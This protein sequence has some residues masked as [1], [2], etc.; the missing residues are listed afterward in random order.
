MLKVL[1]HV[2]Q[3]YKSQPS[4][5]LPT[6]SLL[7]LL[8]TV[9]K[10]NVLTCNFAVGYVLSSLARD[11]VEV[12][13][14]TLLSL[15]SIF[16]QFNEAC[17]QHVLSAFVYNIGDIRIKAPLEVRTADFAFASNEASKRAFLAYATELLLW[18][19]RAPTAPAAGG[20]N[21][22]M[23]PQAVGDANT[24]IAPGHSTDS[25]TAIK[26]TPLSAIQA[27]LP[28]APTIIP[29]VGSYSLQTLTERKV[30]LVNFL[31][32]NVDIFTDTDLYIP[33]IIASTDI[34]NDVQHVGEDL[35]RK[36]SSKDALEDVAI[37]KR[38]FTLFVG[39]TASASQA[40]APANANK[41]RAPASLATGAKILELLSRSRTAPTILPQAIMVL[42][43]GLLATHNLTH[44]KIQTL[45]LVFAQQVVRLLSPAQLNATSPAILSV[46]SKFH[47][48]VKGMSK[49]GNASQVPSP[50]QLESL[51]ISC[52]HAISALGRR[53]P[54]VFSNN[55]DLIEELLNDLQDTTSVVLASALQEALTSICPTSAV[56][57]EAAQLRLKN[58]LA[59]NFEVK[60]DGTPAEGEAAQAAID[61]ARKTSVSVRY[62]AQYYA[63]RSFPFSDVFLRYINLLGT[64]DANNQVA[65]E[66]KIGLRPFTVVD[67]TI[68]PLKEAKET[69][70]SP[71]AMDTDSGN[72]SATP[73]TW[74]SFASMMHLI[75][76][77]LADGLIMASSTF[78]SMIVFLHDLMK[79]HRNMRS[80]SLQSAP[81]EDSKNPNTDEFAQ[82]FYLK[83]LLDAIVQNASNNTSYMSAEH[84]LETM[85]LE[86][87]PGDVAAINSIDHVS[88]LDAVTQTL[89]SGS[90]KPET[91]RI[92]SRIAGLLALQTPSKIASLVETSFNA[93]QNNKS[94]TVRD[95]QIGAVYTLSS[96]VAA[97][98]RTKVPEQS[99]GKS[100]EEIVAMILSVLQASIASKSST[101]LSG[102]GLMLATLEAIGFIG[103]W[104][105]K[106]ANVKTTGNE[107]TLLQSV[108][109]LLPSHDFSIVINAA[110][111]VGNLCL[112]DRKLI[113]D[114]SV[115]KGL[116]ATFVVKNE[117]AH[118]SIGEALSMVAYGWHAAVTA[119]TMIH[120]HQE[121]K[122]QRSKQSDASAEELETGAMRHILQVTLKDYFLSSRPDTR[123]A[124]AIWLLTILKNCGAHPEVVAQLRSIQVGFQ[125]LLG[126][127]N[128][129][130]QEVAGKALSLVYELGDESTK[131][132]LVDSLV[133]ALQK[134]S[135]STFKV[136]A[137]SEIFATG[138]VGM[139]PTGD[140][141]T[142]YRELVTLA[143]EMNQPDL[144]Y[145]FM[146]LSSHNALWNSKKGAAFATGEL[147]R[148]A[149]EQIA[150]H[151]P[152]LVPK[153]YRSSFDPNLKIA[154][155]MDSILQTLVPDLKSTIQTY[156]HVI[157]RDLL[158]NAI[159]PQW[160]TREASCAALADVLP[161]REWDD[162]KDELKDLW[163]RC[164]RV[165]DD[166]KESVRKSAEGFKKAL[167]TLTLR[168]CDPSY[169][170]R[171]HGRI[172]LEIALPHLMSKGLLSSVKEVRA[173]SLSMIQKISKV[174]SF[175]LKPHIS[176][177]VPV[178]LSSLGSLE[179]SAQLNYLEQHSTS[180]GISGDMFDEV[181]VSMSKSSPVHAT[182]D[183]CVQ[184]ADSQN[185]EILGPKIGA[186]LT[187]EQHVATRT[188]AA[189]VITTLAL[190]KPELT[191]LI[192]HKLM[193]ALKKGINARAPIVRKTYGYAMG[194]LSRCAKKRTVEIVVTSLLDSYK[195]STPE[196]TDLRAAVAEALL[197]LSKAHSIPLATPA[198]SSTDASTADAPISAATAESSSAM[199][200]DPPATPTTPTPAE[201]PK[202]TASMDIT[203]GRAAVPVLAP[204]LPI[205][206]PV[207]FI[208]R[209]DSREDTSKLFNKIWEE[210]GAS[211]ALY[212]PETVAAFGVAF[213]ASSWQMKQQGAK[214]L[215]KFAESL[216]FSQFAKQAPELLKML[217][218]G[219][220]GRTWQGKES[221]LNALA[222]LVACAIEMWSKP[223]EHP[224]NTVSADELFKMINTEIARKSL[225][226]KKAAIVCAADV[227]TAFDKFVPDYD[228]ISQVKSTLIEHATSVHVSED[229]SSNDT[230]SSNAAPSAPEKKDDET[231][232]SRSIRQ[233]AIQAL[234]AAFPSTKKASQTEN[235]ATII[236]VLKRT[237]QETIQYTMK[238]AVLNYLKTLVLKIKS[239]DWDEVVRSEDLQT[240]LDSILLPA[241]VDPKYSVVRTAGC[242]TMVELLTQAEHSPEMEKVIVKISESVT[243]A[244]QLGQTPS[245]SERLLTIINRIKAN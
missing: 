82:T 21:M 95:V 170:N 231:A 11:T 93:L 160:R 96:T 115:L 38:L 100:L 168:L 84:Y 233:M 75:S 174:A 22:L 51:Y 31:R 122:E 37:I 155:S 240:I 10:A 133:N 135:S 210:C 171:D 187:S 196:E 12:K 3:R 218:T 182:I 2:N 68:V 244:D 65:Q 198:P 124:S 42:L 57:S 242:G 217:I 28:D 29:Q 227:L 201:S 14:K 79:H 8:Q 61:P 148:R 76:E 151:L 184:Q 200:V 188:A 176:E 189:N 47:K 48:W 212:V 179:N 161:A 141:L 139:T 125:Q 127:T 58:I 90:L 118:F 52:L 105:D 207:V 112:G 67:N 203:E 55:I 147:A 214:S 192:A 59:K 157:L 50:S 191:R 132:E 54:Q 103:R 85:Q 152:Q 1:Q 129:I 66:A 87:L 223:S 98:L 195:Q 205:V 232:L 167:S 213:E 177:L 162:V 19:P 142:T 46:L 101:G 215:A 44:P 143:S 158:H 156:I 16:T 206:V 20:L 120:S 32:E 39:E 163:E 169:T 145:K 220:K 173:I 193:L 36:L 6:D 34:L 166:I 126:D 89:L 121:E 80:K 172:A 236:T 60:K 183:T 35:H 24:F 56:L 26:T 149:K 7:T 111:C 4:W 128:E 140:K 222:K 144:I 114:E 204:L 123:M 17:Q 49:L 138:E 153:L 165:L 237:Y 63:N 107:E 94:I 13:R 45:A 43:S 178:L 211:L 62:V 53:A 146:Q 40:A 234:C 190:T 86:A 9:P 113:A 108:L 73:I 78:Q 102:I 230:S 209:F 159:D 18:T 104:S 243:T 238:V 69:P 110:Y 245:S 219:L 185:I 202:P 208:G 164:F 72:E 175:L 64:S 180:L 88:A 70:S 41:A 25:Q 77:R 194:Q 134:G 239:A 116:L 27:Q 241:I 92:V 97:C 91:A 99:L 119:D 81:G 181:R 15:M 154:H 23:N 216:N 225:E 136:T 228:A 229:S 5:K 199:D 74:P 106:V 109:S 221:L 186:L 224:T 117:E 130:L 137:D 150:P 33:S 197:E 131:K 30:Q 226:Y 71:N 83:L 235:F